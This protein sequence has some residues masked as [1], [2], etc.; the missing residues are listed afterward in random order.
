MTILDR[1][2]FQDGFLRS[3]DMEVEQLEP[4]AQHCTRYTWY[5]SCIPHI[6]HTYMLFLL[7]EYDRIYLQNFPFFKKK[8][9]LKIS[10][11][12]TKLEKCLAKEQN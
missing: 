12:E 10:F 8:I 3:L 5:P 11:R 1:I 6:W 2:I 4:R 7:H 9:S